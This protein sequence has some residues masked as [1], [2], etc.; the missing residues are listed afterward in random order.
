MNGDTLSTIWVN[1]NEIPASG[2][3]CCILASCKDCGALQLDRCLLEIQ[4]N[5]EETV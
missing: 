1:D 3:S 2:D 5:R 4:H